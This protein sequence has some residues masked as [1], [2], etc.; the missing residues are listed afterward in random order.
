MLP[1]EETKRFKVKEWERCFE[2]ETGCFWDVEVVHT[3][4]FP[5]TGNNNYSNYGF[6]ISCGDKVLKLFE[7]TTFNQPRKT[8]DYKMT[9]NYEFEI[10]DKETNKITKY[11]LVEVK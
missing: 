5:V 8:K 7:N 10:F 6:F 1:Y 9:R 4:N 11:K 3:Y 2:G